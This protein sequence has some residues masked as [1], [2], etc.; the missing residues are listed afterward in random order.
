MKNRHRHTFDWV[1]AL[2]GLWL[3]C[4]T[5]VAAEQPNIIVMLCDD[6]RWN[7]LSCAGHPHLKTPNID[8]LADEG[9]YFENMFCTT[10]LCSPS[11]AT[12][13]SGLYAHAHGV[14][15]NFTDYPL[16]LDSFPRRLQESGYETAYIGKWHMGEKSDEPRPGFDYF[17][18]HKGQGK[19]FDT[20]FNFNG[21]DR[22]VVPGYYTNVVTD[23]SVAWMRGQQ[24]AAE[25]KPFMLMIG[26]KAPHSFYFPEEKYAHTF[27]DVEVNY[28]HS[29]FHL[30]ELAGIAPPA[31]PTGVSLVPLLKNPRAEGHPAI[32]YTGKAA[33]IRTDSHRLILHNDGHVELYD[34]QTPAGETAN[35]AAD[36]PQ[37]VARLKSQLLARLARRSAGPVSATPRETNR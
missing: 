9:I 32:A 12:I 15:N 11:R 16:D 22:R 35:I 29:S 14:T 34:H 6:I 33:T 37:L 27:D 17:V 19:Y 20:E 3:L 18:T 24:K 7:A 21:K 10:S 13:L 2:F 1:P 25:S 30:C 4:T 31:D 5:A 23:M 26:Q 8:R 28:P 36:D